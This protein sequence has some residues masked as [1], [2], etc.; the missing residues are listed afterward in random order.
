MRIAESY[1]GMPEGEQMAIDILNC[2]PSPT[3]IFAA[4]DLLAIGALRVPSSWG[5][6]CPTIFP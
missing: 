1:F 3:A 6:R 2:S 4:I 5:V